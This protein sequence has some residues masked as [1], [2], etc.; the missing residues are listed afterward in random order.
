MVMR[1]TVDDGQLKREEVRIKTKAKNPKP[2][3]KKFHI[4]ILGRTGM[5]FRRLAHGGSF[6]GVTWKGY[7][8]Q[9]VRKT[10]GVTVPAHGGVAKL[11]GEGTVLGRR[12]GPGGQRVTASSN[13]LRST[14]RLAAAAG[15]TVRFVRG[16]KVMLM[17]TR[18]VKYGGKQQEDR[19][20]LFFQVPKDLRVAERLAQ[21]HLE[22]S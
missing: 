21:E 8:P 17:I 5:M 14:G 16:G 9:Y 18:N 12:R 4:Y 6:R 7:K 2:M 20:F 1:I 22:S 10:D 15:T 3:L 13:L 19:P 11:R